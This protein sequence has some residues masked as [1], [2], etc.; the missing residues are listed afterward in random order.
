[1]KIKTLT[2]TSRLSLLALFTAFGLGA[3]VSTGEVSHPVNN[4]PKNQN[5]EIPALPPLPPVTGTQNNN[6]P[7]NNAVTAPQ[8]NGEIAFARMGFS[9]LPNWSDTDLEAARQA[10]RNS[11]A[12][13]AKRNDAYY[14]GEKI[15]YAG[16]VAD[17]KGVCSLANN[18]DISTR[19][20]FENNFTPWRLSAKNGGRGKLTSYFEPILH[21]S[22]NQTSV[23][24]EPL[25][26]KP[27][28]LITLNL[29]DF[30]PSLA[31][32]KIVGR[33]NGNNFIP[34]RARGEINASNAPIIAW[35]KMGEALSLQIQGS[36]RLLLDNGQ[37][38]RAAFVATN[39]QPFGSVARELIKRGELPASQASA[40]NITK[41]FEKAAPNDARSVVNANPR[42]TFFELQAIKNPA[43]GPRGSQ[44]VPLV[45]SGSL[46][47]DPSIH[48]YG[49]PIFIFANASA[50]GNSIENTLT[51]LVITQDSGGAIKGP[52]RGDL[53]YGTGDEAGFAAGRINHEADWWVL[54]PNGLDPTKK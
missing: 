33:I 5:N 42:T 8:A 11:C 1:M 3:C 10:F 46:A 34:Y 38:L 48:A 25:Y 14:L 9:D 49:V 12:V 43:D 51:R 27:S 13:L 37:Q 19:A 18:P 50:L 22:L 23:Y 53:Y 16:K 31:G 52:I 26:G 28:D 36:G 21:A 32:K 4:P 45:A 54:L 7:P 44:G 35:A 39:G 17:W 20:F 47:I 24:N 41:W 6:P 15:A 40:D 29:S 2:N 30:D